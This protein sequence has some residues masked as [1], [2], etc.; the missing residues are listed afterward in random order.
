M[1]IEFSDIECNYDNLSLSEFLQTDTPSG[2]ID[3]FSSSIDTLSDIS[4]SLSNCNYTIYPEMKNIFRAFYTTPLSNIK[5][6]VLG[7]DPYHNGSATGLAFSVAKGYKINPS[8]KNI[9]KEVLSC[10][11]SVDDRCGDLSNWAKQGVFLINTSLTVKESC[12]GSHLS[13]WKDFTQQLIEYISDH[14][15]RVVFLLWGDKAQSYEKYFD[16]SKH[17]V[18]K[19]SHPSPLSAYRGFLGSKCFNRVNEYLSSNNK[20]QIDWSIYDSFHS[21]LIYYKL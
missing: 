19:T 5:V 1:N 14:C 12:A 11:F 4:F 2:W 6:V 21:K 10:G 20:K 18:V 8:L 9:S 15:D 17:D 7:Q 13:I 3:F 16:K